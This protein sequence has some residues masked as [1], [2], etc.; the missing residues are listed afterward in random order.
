M[1]ADTSRESTLSPAEDLARALTRFLGA[2]PVP[3]P[4]A[5]FPLVM[6]IHEVAAAMGMKPESVSDAARRGALPMKKRLGRYVVA[7]DVLRAWLLESEVV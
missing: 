2:A 4:W 3:D 5:Q 6:G 7:Q 1:T